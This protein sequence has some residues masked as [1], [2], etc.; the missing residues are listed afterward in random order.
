MAIDVAW[1]APLGYHREYVP[2]LGDGRQSAIGMLHAGT[3]L[4]GL[5]GFV[6]GA[7]GYRARI[8]GFADTD[9][10]Q[11]D[12]LASADMGF[13]IGASL[14]IAGYRGRI[15]SSDAEFPITEHLVGPRITYRVDDFLDVFAGS[16][17]T[18]SAENALHQ[19][20]YLVGFAT[21]RTQLDRLKGFLG[22]KRRP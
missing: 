13:W 6:Q 20:Q 1:Q 7:G 5:N 18:I 14:M 2:P 8:D 10:V 9:P 19:N 11:N 3:T 16:M 15:E 4:S 21:K 17:H 22:S 12:V